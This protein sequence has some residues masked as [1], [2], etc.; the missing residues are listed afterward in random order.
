[1]NS[2]G[3]NENEI[4][5]GDWVRYYD[6]CDRMEIAQVEYVV[7]G[8]EEPICTNKGRLSANLI[9]EVRHQA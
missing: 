1:M 7:P 9:L 2:A 4:R 5:T 3:I 8:T 6:D